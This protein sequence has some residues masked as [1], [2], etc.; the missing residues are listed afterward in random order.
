MIVKM[1]NYGLKKLKNAMQEYKKGNISARSAKE[2]L[3]D[4]RSR[5]R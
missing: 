5:I 4:A 3:R 1:K 2:A